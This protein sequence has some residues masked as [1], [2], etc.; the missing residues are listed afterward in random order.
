MPKRA[1]TETKHD[2]MYGR[3]QIFGEWLTHQRLLAG[4]TQAQTA[5]AIGVSRRQWIRYELGA[6]VPVKRMDL[7]SRVLNVAPDTMLDRAGYRTSFKRHAAK[8]QLGRIVDLMAAGRLQLAM[9]GL[10]KLNDRIMGIKA[11]A[12]P[13]LGL[14]GTDYTHALV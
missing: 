7:M 9:L 5:V 1:Q 10:L 11:A 6:K 4:F 3:W 2:Y 12:G 14:D 8:E 13:R